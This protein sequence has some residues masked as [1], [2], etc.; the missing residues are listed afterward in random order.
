MN[1]IFSTIM[2]MALFLGGCNSSND[3]VPVPPTPT[4]VSLHVTPKAETLDVGTT[5]TYTAWA[6]LSDDEYEDVSDQV[7]WSLADNTGAVVF[8]QMNPAQ[9]RAAVVGSDFVVATLGTLTTTGSQR[10]G[11]TVVEDTLVSITV[12]PNDAELIL[13]LTAQYTATGTYAGGGEQDLTDESTWT[14]ANTG[15]ITID[16]NGLASPVAVGN[17]TITASFDGQTGNTTVGV[18]DPGNVDHIVIE[19]EG[20]NFIAGTRK[21]FKAIAHFSD[22]SEPDLDVT[23]DCNWSSDDT[24][25]VFP[26]LGSTIKGNFQASADL[27]GATNITAELSNNITTTIRVTVDED[28]KVIINRTEIVPEEHTLRVGESKIFIVDAITQDSVKITISNEPGHTFTVDN[29]DFL[30]IGNTPAD[31]GKATGRSVGTATITSTFEYEGQVFVT[32]AEV[33]IT[34]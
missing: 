8:D 24:N 33:I 26:V 15:F 13:E 18:T 5:Q 19:P 28:Y 29:D 14:S 32:H 30:V 7:T 23:K 1:F 2:L 31:N 3:S 27:T 11:V 34:P 20:Y 9:A 21:Q 16:T 22:T 6:E 25:L 4:I 17:T 10:A 12:T